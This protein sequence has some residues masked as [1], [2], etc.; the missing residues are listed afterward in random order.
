MKTLV[1]W[2]V[3]LNN[4]VYEH[5]HGGITFVFRVNACYP[6]FLIVDL[7]SMMKLFNFNP[8]DVM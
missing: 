5:T 2:L 6:T 1:L 3:T 4:E 8:F 7:L